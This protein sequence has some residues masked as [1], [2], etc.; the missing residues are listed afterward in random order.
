MNC[1]PN[2]V[3]YVAR[4]WMVMAFCP[5]CGDRRP[6]LRNG[7]VVRVLR[8]ERAVWMIEE[9]IRIKVD[10]SCGGYMMGVVNGISDEIL[11]PLRD[12]GNDA[13]DETLD[14]LPAPAKETA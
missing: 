9:P 5:S 4:E 7:T 12:P 8:Y 14:W 2:D 6:M 3:A 11:R 1:R 13:R 10:F